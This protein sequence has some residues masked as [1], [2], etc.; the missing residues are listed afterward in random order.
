MEGS[1]ERHRV[2]K[3]AE[4]PQ[5]VF[6]PWPWRFEVDADEVATDS[7][8]PLILTE[9]QIVEV[10]ECWQSLVLSIMAPFRFGALD[11]VNSCRQS[12]S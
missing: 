7:L 10:H 8:E 11:L 9:A 1:D 3:G 12:G 6:R 2:R 5:H 4:S